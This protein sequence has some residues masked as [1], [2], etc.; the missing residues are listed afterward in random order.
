[1]TEPL[2]PMN[3]IEQT[4]V[5]GSP[6]RNL[7]RDTVISILGMAIALVWTFIDAAW[8]WKV[9]ITVAIAVVAVFGERFLPKSFTTRS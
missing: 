7:L 3:R 5:S 4:A 2:R 8:W 9:A 6:R 1:M